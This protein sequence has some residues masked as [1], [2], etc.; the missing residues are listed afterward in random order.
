MNN[1]LSK[2]KFFTR[3]LIMLMLLSIVMV[4]P[5]AA[6]RP[7]IYVTP[8]DNTAASTTDYG[9]ALYTTTPGIIAYIQF[10][11]PDGFD[12]SST[13]ISDVVN[14]GEGQVISFANQTLVYAVYDPIFVPRGVIVAFEFTDIVNPNVAGEYQVNF[15]TYQYNYTIDEFSILQESESDF[16]TINPSLQ[17][18][19]HYGPTGSE[20]QI[21]GQYF[22]AGANIDLF[23]NGT[24]IGTAT[25]NSTGQ[26]TQNY[27]ITAI[28][29]NVDT[30]LFFNATTAS[31][32]F[33]E[34]EFY[35]QSPIL[36]GYYSSVIPGDIV[37]LE[38]YYFKASS[39][40]ELYWAQ[41][42]VDEVH[43][44][45][46]TSDAEGYFETTFTV[47]NQPIGLYDVQQLTLQVAR[48]TPPLVWLPPV[49]Y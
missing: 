8:V 49:Y 29:Q 15:T 20:V 37:P 2:N 1:R 3:I 10:D 24:A 41:G 28:A 26:F 21:I 46:V 7:P 39:S 35:L 14:L 32:L 5:V 22:P 13:D 38:G 19:P 27:T 6:A 48:L 12:I 36:F 31:G 18:T 11:F 33:A 30:E 25:A 44:G 40:I 47:P 9:M 16:F 43:L 17:V 42:T 4:A 45:T 23:F 34:A